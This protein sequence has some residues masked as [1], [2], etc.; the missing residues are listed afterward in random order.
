LSL[1]AKTIARSPVW[2]TPAMLLPSAPVTAAR[3]AMPD[4]GYC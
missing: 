2:L 1:V 3:T 4:G